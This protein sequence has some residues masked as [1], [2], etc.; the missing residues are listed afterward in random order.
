MCFEEMGLL[1]AE[2]EDPPL[3]PGDTIGGM[4]MV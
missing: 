2:D 1:P 3:S 4:S